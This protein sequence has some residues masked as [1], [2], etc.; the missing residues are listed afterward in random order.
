MESESIRTVECKGHPILIECLLHMRFH[1]TVASGISTTRQNVSLFNL[2]IIQE[3][4]IA[5]LHR[6]FLKSLPPIPKPDPYGEFGGA[7]RTGTGFTGVRQINLGFLETTQGGWAGLVVLRQLQG[8]WYL[9]RIRLQHSR[10]S[11]LLR[12]LYTWLW[13][14]TY[15]N[16]V[17]IFSTESVVHWITRVSQE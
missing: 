15:P 6:S 5:I 2:I 10:H 1:C 14:P 17:P 3:R 9:L 8:S 7:G 4:L 12:I 16:D 11:S 13:E